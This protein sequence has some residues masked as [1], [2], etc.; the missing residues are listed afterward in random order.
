MSDVRLSVL[1]VV[2]LTACG[3]G[4]GKARC[5][6]APVGELLV[7]GDSILF[8]NAPGCASVGD[9]VGRELGLTV[10]VAAK[11][12]AKVNP[13]G[14][15]VFGDIR[16]QYVPHGWKWVVLNGG[17]NDMNQDCDCEAAC[18]EVL[19]SIVTQDGQQ[20]D[21]PALVDRARADGAGVVLV[22]YA[23]VDPDAKWG[24]GACNEAIV[25]LESRYRT[26]ADRHDDVV[27]VDPSDAVSFRGTPGAYAKDG[28]H[29]SED[30]SAVMGRLIADA[31][32]ASGR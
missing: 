11:T 10:H 1:S 14:A 19:D 26:L 2:L 21:I 32:A 6:S 25:A 7:M 13:A 17:L 23:D 30:G 12:G 8:F 27:F 15:Y 9:A 28:V 18:G 31:I 3:P 5:A 29:P 20:G 4:F 16:E 22:G 24:F